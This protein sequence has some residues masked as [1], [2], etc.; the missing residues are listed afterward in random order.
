M[1]GV[2]PIRCGGPCCAFDQRRSLLDRSWAG[3][4]GLGRLLHR[5]GLCRDLQLSPI[6]SDPWRPVRLDGCATGRVFGPSAQRR[7]T[8]GAAGRLPSPLCPGRCMP[9]PQS[10]LSRRLAKAG[11]A[12]RARPCCGS[13]IPDRL[14][15]RVRCP[16]AG[17]RQALR[18]ACSGRL[19]RKPAGRS[20]RSLR[21]RERA[22]RACGPC[23]PRRAAS[24][25]DTPAPCAHRRLSLAVEDEREPQVLLRKQ[26][27]RETA[28]PGLDPGH[29]QLRQVRYPHGLSGITVR[30]SLK[31]GRPR[32]V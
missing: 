11:C 22:G 8:E 26:G 23:S 31:A 10:D 14:D 6:P 18:A 16:H 13:R 19:G 20:G 29:R 21:E 28:G 2:S 7:D 32:A 17:D 4:T 30:L 15:E 25:G 3:R 1:A 9:A 27:A 12:A 24:P 5:Y